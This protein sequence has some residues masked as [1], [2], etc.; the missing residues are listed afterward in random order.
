MSNDPFSSWSSSS[1]SLKRPDNANHLSEPFI[2]KISIDNPLSSSQ[3]TFGYHN[4]L[5][6]VNNYDFNCAPWIFAR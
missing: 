5:V 4:D 6:T 3:S 2:G 1:L